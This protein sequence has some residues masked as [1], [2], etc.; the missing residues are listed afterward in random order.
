MRRITVFINSLA[1]CAFFS[2]PLF[3][4]V[5]GQSVP[6]LQAASALNTPLGVRSYGMGMAQTANANDLSAMYYNPAGL[7]T[8]NYFEYALSYHAAAAG[9]SATSLMASIPLPYGTLG[10]Q[11]VMNVPQDNQYVQNAV[12]I[13]PDRNKYS[14]IAGLSYGA[15]VPYAK[16]LLNFGTTVKWFGA[17]FLSS[18][19]VTSYPQQQKGL[20]IDL[21]LSSV[22]DPAHYSNAL[23]WFPRMAVGVAARNL[24]PLFGIDNEVAPPDNRSEYNAG[25]SFQFPYKLMANF[26]VVNTLV[27]PTRFRFG[28]E[29]WPIY[30]LALRGGMTVSGSGDQY[31]S[32][33]WG[34]GLGDTVQKS[35]LSFEYSGANEYYNGFGVALETVH[36]T[37]HRFAFHHSF[38][39]TEFVRGREVPIRFNERYTHRLR[40]ARALQPNEIIADTIGDISQ[41]KGD[42]QSDMD[43]AG[44]SKVK[45]D[46]APDEAPAQPVPTDPKGKKKPEPHRPPT[47]IGK[48][49]VA[50][51]P[52]SIEMTAGRPTSFPVKER[53][54]GN[55][56]IEV[57]SG[58][59][60]RLIPQSKLG[61]AP[62][63]KK[64]E[65]D[66]VYFKRLQQTL[67][68]DLIVFNKLYIDGN[69][70]DL[71]LITI[72]FRRGAK[73]VSAQTEVVG[74]DG[75]EGE[76]VARARA[77]FAKEY[78]ALLG[79]LK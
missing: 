41:D 47:I 37:Y 58:G 54:R 14:Y 75:Q 1:V 22:F 50:V 4:A 66:S 6:A 30:F 5:D 38:E 17:N 62:E 46:V 24:H 69:T 43:A 36:Q 19:Q 76:F 29:Y 16:R 71:R 60:G 61:A 2:T 70:G 31:K 63:Q 32:V 68:A 40:F 12:N 65:L 39:S 55:F 28:L 10:L 23:R 48:Y 33:H 67:G 79:E 45:P 73:G 27:N 3:A 21:G 77:E 20:F 7:A 26:D 51:Y 59:V 56:L 44:G 11:G 57:S 78:K 8:I 25:I 72:Y 42:Y 15:A 35:K 52:V 9:V 64:G 13:L 49:L 53:L 18:P 34:F 74:S